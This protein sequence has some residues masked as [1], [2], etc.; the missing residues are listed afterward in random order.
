MSSSRSFIRS[1]HFIYLQPTQKSFSVASHEFPFRKKN[2]FLFPLF[3]LLNE[4]Q[5]ATCD[6]EEGKE[7]IPFLKL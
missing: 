6:G 4:Q 2:I 7:K 1:F 3:E 5:E